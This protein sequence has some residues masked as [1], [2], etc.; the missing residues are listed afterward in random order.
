MAADV[1]ARAHVP[2]ASIVPPASESASRGRRQS[3]SLTEAASEELTR[4]AKLRV[5][6]ICA[7]AGAV[8]PP[9]PRVPSDSMIHSGPSVAGSV[10]Q[11]ATG[12]G[13]DVCPREAARRR[14]R[15][16]S[17]GGIPKKKVMDPRR[18]QKGVLTSFRSAV[19]LSYSG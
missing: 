10:Q 12:S 11:Q 7:S 4:V 17:E 5:L 16:L 8:D 18:E 9:T 1:P 3:A 6:A 19:S 15:P 2:D 13:R 14:G